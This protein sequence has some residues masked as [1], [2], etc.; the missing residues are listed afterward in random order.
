MNQIMNFLITNFVII[1]CL[2][3]AGAYI[4]IT[5]K[6]F[7]QKPKG[8]Q[9]EK[10]K[11]WLIQACLEAEKDLQSG[12]G[13][14]KLR[15]VYNKFLNIQAFQWVARIVTFEQFS[16]WVRVALDKAKEMLVNNPKLAEYTYGN[17]WKSEVEKLRSQLNDKGN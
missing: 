16:D 6:E 8:E 2:L 12:T 3:A 4:G 5:V 17:S 11:Q 9:I 13:Q 7:L 14:L 15:V 1:V 10:V